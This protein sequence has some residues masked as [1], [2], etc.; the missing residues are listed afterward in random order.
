MRPSDEEVCF[1]RIRAIA[2]GMAM[3][4]ADYD[5]VLPFAFGASPV[6]RW[7]WN[8]PHP[9]P[10]D[11][12]PSDE[13]LYSAFA[14]MWA[15]SVL[16]YLDLN[17]SSKTP[18]VYDWLRCPS[19]RAKRVAGVDYSAARRRPAYA[20]YTYNGLLHQY[21]VGLVDNPATVP[22][23]WEG[24]GR[25]AAF[26]FARSNPVLRCEFNEQIPCRYTSCSSQTPLRGV[27]FIPES[28]LWIHPKGVA[29]AFVD[30]HAEWRRLGL[31]V[32]GATN[33][34]YDPFTNSNTRGVPSD[35]WQ[36]SC[37]Y[38]LLFR[39]RTQ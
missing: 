34:S 6:G 9:V 11:W 21:P 2:L 8:D 16:P 15:N 39:P 20:S 19:V 4:A 37:G 14:S 23:V 32:G 26:G 28:S 18:T 22:L 5:E 10:H 27:M 3:Y 31:V 25:Q 29:F 17:R 13:S 7:L 35:Y 12:R 1:S 30:G 38:A 33:P 36:D 24:L